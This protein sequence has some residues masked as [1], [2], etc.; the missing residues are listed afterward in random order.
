MYL[1]SFS[2]SE[3][4]SHKEDEGMVMVHGGR[5]GV[6]QTLPSLARG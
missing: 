2:S 5:V 3:L 6:A 4:V 1:K